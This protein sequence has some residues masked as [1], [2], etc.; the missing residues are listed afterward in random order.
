MKYDNERKCYVVEINTKKLKGTFELYI[1]FD[2]DTATRWGED[3][4]KI[5]EGPREYPYIWISSKNDTDLICNRI[6]YSSYSA[7]AENRDCRN[8]ISIFSQYGYRKSRHGLDAPAQSF[9][10]EIR[11][12][13]EPFVSQL[14]NDQIAIAKAKLLKLE[15]DRDRLKSEIDDHYAKIDDLNSKSYSLSLLIHGKKAELEKMEAIKA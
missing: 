12:S 9:Y 2:L 10:S 14:F 3:G 15:R 4:K 5:N 1:N 6:E 11:N 8:G 7:R 13:L